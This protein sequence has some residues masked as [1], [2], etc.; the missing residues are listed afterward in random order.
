MAERPIPP[1][2]TL[3]K[4]EVIQQLAGGFE[5]QFGSPMPRL[6]VV[7]EYYFGSTVENTLASHQQGRLPINIYRLGG[8]KSPP[9]ISTLEL[10]HHA[11]E[12]LQE[13]Q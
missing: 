1:R 3:K 12:K 2:L 4:A 13:S 6:D 8:R 11:Y 9:V 10:A 7:C 5:K